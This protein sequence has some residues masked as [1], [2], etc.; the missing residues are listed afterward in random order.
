[1]PSSL[2]KNLTRNTLQS[3]KSS[4]QYYVASSLHKMFT[5]SEFLQ[6][7]YN[8][9]IDTETC[10]YCGVEFSSENRQTVDHIYPLIRD[11]LPNKKM[12]FCYQNK[13]FC[14]STCNSS[15]SN[16]CHIQWMKK[17]N[18]SMERLEV[19]N[20]QINLVPTFS[21]KTYTLLISKYKRF[22]NNHE[23]NIKELF[24]I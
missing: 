23:N 7:D 1:M 22:M 12:V 21:N 17:K 11:G 16:H 15:K 8:T 9:L 5:P 24:F 4:I 18:F 19:I 14:C 2:H 6:G 3:R 13:G 10:I 20:K